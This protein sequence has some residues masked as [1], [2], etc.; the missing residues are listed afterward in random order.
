MSE[1]FNLLSYGPTITGVMRAARNDELEER[2][3]SAGRLCIY[4]GCEEPGHTYRRNTQYL[5]TGSNWGWACDEHEALDH[6]E[7]EDVWREY[8]RQS[9][10]W[11]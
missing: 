4:P 11:K 6:E 5:D 7:M 9:W 1:R 10:P 2:Q 3:L 8:R